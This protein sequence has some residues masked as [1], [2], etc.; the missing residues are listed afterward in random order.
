MPV[1]TQWYIPEAVIYVQFWGET[2]VED[3][4][5]YIYDAYQLSDLSSRS[6]VHVIADSSRVTKG[7]NIKEVM[8]T[9]S[10]VKPHPKAGWNITVGEKDKIIRFTTDVARQ[11]LRLRTRSFNTIDE[12]I[13]FLKDI[14]H[15]I[16]WTTIN[17]K[18]LA[19]D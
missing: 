7:I 14:D 2:T 19:D 17:Q 5:Q 16:D 10:N 6:L 4:Q 3:M 11:L 18:V 15:S 8:K 12:A 9:V 1:K 13:T